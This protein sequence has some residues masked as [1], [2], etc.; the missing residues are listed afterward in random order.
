MIEK[1]HVKWKI[2]F[3]T[4]HKKKFALKKGSTAM[5][6][7]EKSLFLR[8]VKVFYI[9]KNRHILLGLKQIIFTQKRVSNSKIVSKSFSNPNV[10]LCLSYIA[11]KSICQFEWSYNLIRYN[12]NFIFI[13]KDECNTLY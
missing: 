13:S 5:S 11:T 12:E 7:K 10:R 6:L 9:F 2:L 4:I 3:L 8:E 1:K